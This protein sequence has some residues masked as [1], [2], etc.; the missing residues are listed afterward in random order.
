VP[1]PSD[2]DPTPFEDDRNQ[3]KELEEERVPW[4]GP[5]A[6]EI[7][8]GKSRGEGLLNPEEIRF[9]S[10]NDVRVEGTVEVEGTARADEL[11]WAEAA[12]ALGVSSAAPGRII[13][14]Q[15]ISTVGHNQALCARLG[16]C[17]MG[18]SQAGKYM[19]A[20]SRPKF[21]TLRKVDKSQVTP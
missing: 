16:S 7:K 13:K 2:G 15:T 12:T 10:P 11:P 5:L 14:A 17:R 21:E 19:S 1:T 18:A 8:E 9:S 20:R 3:G 6:D 4:S